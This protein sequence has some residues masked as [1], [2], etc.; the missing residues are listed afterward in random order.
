M[1][2]HIFDDDKKYPDVIHIGCWTHTRRLFVE[3]VESGRRAMDMILLIAE[4]FTKADTHNMLDLSPNQLEELRK[5]D[6]G[7]ILGKIS[8]LAKKFAN[9]TQLMANPLMAKAVNYM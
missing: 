8:T 6:F 7:I 2:Y 9:D 3:A 5:C 4:L 1:G